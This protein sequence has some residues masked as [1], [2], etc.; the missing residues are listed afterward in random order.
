MATSSA[1]AIML[2]TAPHHTTERAKRLRHGLSVDFSFAGMKSKS[3]N[4]S[5]DFEGLNGESTWILMTQHFTGMRQRDT[6]TSEAAP[7]LWLKHFLAQ[8]N[9]HCRNKCLCM[10][11][12]GELFDNLEVENLFI[13]ARHAMCPTGANASNQNG[14]VKRDHCTI[15]DTMHAFLTRANLLPKFCPCAFCNSL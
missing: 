1:K 2:A 15:A 4:R 6:R 7:V 9:L 14:P 13:K 12:G 11:Q 5:T 8:H 10:D 3:G